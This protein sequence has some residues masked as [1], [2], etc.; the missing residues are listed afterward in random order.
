MGHAPCPAHSGPRDWFA[1]CS[2][3]PGFYRSWTPHSCTGIRCERHDLPTRSGFLMQHSSFIDYIVL[4]LRVIVYRR[5]ETFSEPNMQW[6]KLFFF[7]PILS[8]N[9]IFVAQ[10]PCAKDGSCSLFDWV[11]QKKQTKK[12]LPQTMTR[13][14]SKSIF[15]V[16]ICIIH[17]QDSKW[18]LLIVG[19]MC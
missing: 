12:T 17:E 19:Q 3:N 15:V 7:Y 8:L 16:L 10:R 11:F 9:T 4:R 2:A 1:H 18:S 5:N 13:K 6:T 14:L